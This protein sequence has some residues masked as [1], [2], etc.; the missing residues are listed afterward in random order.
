MF[1]LILR[2]LIINTRLRE[3]LGASP[4]VTRPALNSEQLGNLH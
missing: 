1:Y 2:P 3:I 4:K